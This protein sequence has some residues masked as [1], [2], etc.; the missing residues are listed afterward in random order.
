MPPMAAF[1]LLLPRILDRGENIVSRGAQARAGDELL[2]PGAA[3]GFAQIA[4]AASC[5]FS[6]LEVFFR[7]RVAILNTGDEIVP[8]EAE[9]G[10]AQIRN[11][12]GP[13]LAALVRRAGGEPWLLPTAPDNTPALEAALL[14]ACEADMVLISGG[15]S[16]G[17]F[18]L[19]EPVMATSARD[20]TSPESA[21]SPANRW[22]SARFLP[23]IPRQTENATKWFGLPGNPVSSAVTFLL[24]A[25]PVVRALAGC[26][27]RDPRFALARLAEN[28]KGKSE[29]PQR[30]VFV[31]GVKIGPH[32]FSA[33][34]LQFRCAARRAAIGVAAWNG[35]APAI[36]A[37]WPTPIAFWFC[38]KMPSAPRLQN[39]RRRDRSHSACLR[40]QCQ[41]PQNFRKP[42]KLSHFDAARAS[43]AWWT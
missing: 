4:L 17:K 30:R 2:A 20:S 9:P 23:Q 24:F 31:V 10:P 37:P 21:F 19:V 6:S 5:G 35:R 27:H 41:K 14:L 13:M 12:N 43:P 18:D 15:V 38:L 1:A 32:P 28:V 33:R 8:V 34:A 36:L 22:S 3:I 7:P 40:I 29:G 16:A 42:S 11:S 25:A 26:A 39:R